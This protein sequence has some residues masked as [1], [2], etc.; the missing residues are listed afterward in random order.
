MRHLIFLFADHFEPRSAEA[1]AAWKEGY[2]E[3]AKAFT[4][5]DGRSPRHTW[6]YDGED[7]A[8]L[9][10]LGAL[11]RMGLGEIEV[12][13]HHGHDTADGLREKLE[14][15]KAAYARS[16]ALITAGPNPVSTFGFVHGKWSLD[17]SRGDEHCG[18]NNEL[19]VLREANCYADFTFPAWGRMQ[20]KK[21]N[22]MLMP[23]F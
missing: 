12:H 4:D 22:S 15:R 1:V 3:V 13:L 19:A 9:D 23:F 20:P 11:C 18:V 17:N 10:S 7:P 8:V 21:H 5:S 16:G 14:R 6:F 2:P